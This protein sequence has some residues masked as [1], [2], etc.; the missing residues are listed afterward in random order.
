M[1]FEIRR[2][3]PGDA[4]QILDY[5]RRV[6]G[7]TDNL[8]FGAEGLPFSVDEE[9]AYLKQ[10]LESER[11]IVLV[12]VQDGKI[13]ADGGLDSQP[14]RMAHRA[15]LGLSVLKD[16]WHQGI[17]TALMKALLEHARQVGFEVLTLEV[18]SDNQRAIRLYERFGFHKAGTHPRY[19]KLDGK[20][21]DVDI[22][23]CCL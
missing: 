8:T 20:Y 9:S 11:D 2:A 3:C 10:R 4:Q 1:D 18:R 19:M 13:I 5:L 6:G 15:V 21:I 14:R 7:E 12:A 22:M 23:F 16:Y 17:G